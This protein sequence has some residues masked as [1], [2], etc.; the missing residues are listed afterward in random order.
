MDSEDDMLDAHDMYAGDDDY[1]SGGTDDDNNDSDDD[2][3][4][5]NGLFEESVDGSAMI[6][7]VRSQINYAVLKE[8]DIRRHQND[9]I[10]QVSMILSLSYVEASILLLHW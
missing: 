5:Y 1:Y 3:D 9:D 4:D 6:A 10:G 7:S 2:V 8:G